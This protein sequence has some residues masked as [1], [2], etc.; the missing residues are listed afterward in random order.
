S[1][2]D[3]LTFML[4]NSSPTGGLL[5]VTPTDV[6]GYATTTSLNVAHLAYTADAG[7][8][9]ASSTLTVASASLSNGTCG[10]FGSESPAID[11]AFT[12]TDGT[13]YRFTLTGTDL[14]GN[15]ATVTQTVKVDTTA[16]SQPAI[17]FTG[18]TPG[19]T[20]ATGSTMWY[21]PT[22]GASFTVNANGSTDGES[23]IATYTFSGNAAQAGNTLLVTPGGGTSTE[24]VHST[25][26]AGLDSLDAS[27]DVKADST[28]PAGGSLTVNGGAAYLTSG[29]TVAIATTPYTDGGSGLANEVLTVQS[30]TLAANN[31]GS[32]GST[33]DISGSASYGV[34][35]GNCYRF[36]LTATDNVGNATV[37]T[38]TV[39]VD[40][41]APVAPAI[42]FTGLSSGN[43][44]VNGTT[45]FYRPSAGGAVTVNATGASDP[46]T[47]IASY[48][49]TPLAGFLS[50]LQTGNKVD[51]IFDG[52]SNGSGAQSVSAVNNAGV[53]STPATPFT[54]T[55]DSG[56]P[57]G[58][59]LSINP[60]SG[61]LTVSIAKTDFADAISGIAT[62]VVTRSNPQ[63]PSSPGTCPLGGYTGST[64]VG[65]SDTVPSDG[66]CYQYT[67][68]GTDNVGNTA[69]FQTIVLVD[70]TGPA[71]GSLAY[72]DGLAT[73]GS[74]SIDWVS[75][76]DPESG[77]AS[78]QIERA[79]ATL[80][81]STCGGFGAFTP[82]GGPVG[83]S[84]TVDASVAAGNCYAYRLVVTNNTG[85]ASTFTS[86]SVAK[87]TNASPITTS[88]GNPAGVYLGG[89]TVWVGP[90]AASLPWKLELTNLGQNGVTTAT[91]D[92]KSAATF[93]SAPTTSTVASS[94]PFQSGTYTW[95]GTGTLTDTIHVIR[96]P[97]GSDD[98]VDVRSDTTN[99]SGSVSYPNATILIHSVP[100]STTGTDAESG[101]SSVSVQRSETTLTGA[102]CGATW[103]AFAPVTLSSGNDTTVAD[104][105]CYRYQ[106]VVTDH[107]GNSSTFGSAS[108]VQIPD[109]TAPTLLSAA[110]NVA[111]TQLT[112]NMSEPL[113]GTATTQASAFTVAYDGVVQ[114]T[115]TGIAVAGS[116]VT[117]NLASA[118]NNSE[119]V[120][121]RYSQP[122]SAGERLRDSASPTKNETANF[123]PSAVVN[124]TPDA[125]APSVVSASVNAS[126]LTILFTETL[127]GAAP[128]P[129]AFTVTIGST[130]RTIT[131][132]SM[133]GKIVTLTFAPAVTS[134]DSVVVSYSTP[135]LN[136]LSDASSNAVAPFTRA[137]AN[138]TPIVAPPTGGGGGV[139]T[140]Q[141]PALASSSPDDG[142]T[143]RAAATI[144]LT[145]N[146]AVSWTD[147]TVTR[148][149]G[150]VTQLDPS[151]GQSATWALANATEGLYVVRGTLAAG[152]S[153]ADVLTHF[154]VWV[155]PTTGFESLV[156]P[157]QKNAVPFAAGELRSSDG[158]TTLV[159]PTGAFSD[160]V[161]VEIVPV[162]LN[163][164][165]GLPP[166]SRIVNVSAFT[167]STHAP[168]HDLGGVADIRF[169]N[170]GAGS[171]PVTST[172][173]K[174][175]RDIP[176]LPTLNLPAGQADG[177]F[178][179]SD[180]TVHVLARH[181]GYYA[182]VGPQVSTRLAMRIITV[183]R[184]WLE[185]RAFV[186]VRMSLTGPARVTGSFV[187]P[188]GTIV[189]GQAIKTPTRHA[190]VTILRVPLTITKPGIYR[191]QMHAEGLGQVVNRTAKI[192]FLATKPASPVWQDGAVR[193]TVVHGAQ[194]LHSLGSALGGHFVVTRVTDAALY[195]AVDTKHPTAA[196]VVVV[197]LRTIPAYTLAGL[198]ALLPE[199]KIIGLSATP[200]RAGAYRSIGVSAVLPGDASAA[201]VAKT[202]RALVR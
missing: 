133:S 51:V 147:M 38:S 156:P 158:S 178:L 92:G 56:A 77:I 76:S 160:S 113:D 151:S 29:T 144:T 143:V 184:L 2:N 123:G 132:V 117:L 189:P 13:C 129:T 72:V 199:V 149:N 34:S 17:V 190:G 66:Q 102:T 165:T 171:H 45:I 166:G 169:A 159:W 108:V 112:L 39:K 135:A 26:R 4:D 23:G 127:A 187:A 197:D 170:A 36:T 37:L 28:A 80:T 31:C 134:N 85:L 99:P 110:T 59:L 86:P 25:N 111:G 162:A 136:G 12:A 137:V 87:I 71:G 20:F 95:D 14:V 104:S 57:T 198:H 30:A 164:V 61:S 191:L 21:R 69:T 185:N 172:D 142:S 98:F 182:L 3:V 167:R 7:S 81:G 152:G 42:S 146:Q 118:P 195:D 150:S 70:T 1:G 43:T 201:L 40:T 22:S 105:T 202:A 141:A 148:P 157:V 183:R 179:D 8:G 24:T 177:W 53:S 9:V 121:V 96:N 58:G 196:A 131:N 6:N 155:P 60:Y 52:T 140:T 19:N 49:F 62:N 79:A 116:T 122:S 90:A 192:R 35:N 138:Q 15:T 153:S 109:V 200:S 64:V 41:T 124:N 97:G 33:S 10:S 139:A 103:S 78:V 163:G 67:L 27:Y 173:G 89:T 115:P 65:A 84:P 54:V 107:V 126:A 120:T 88:A 130:T 161:V 55:P 11:G 68:T 46:E 32:Y 5:N 74:V 128:D 100:V 101:I 73:L 83:S 154:T 181:L 106:V 114:P 175:W 82:L 94:A 18:L 176:G 188:D 47:G 194:G 91:W 63:A 125:V 16:P 93:T 48:A 119:T 44:Y 186:A 145:A 180:G 50:A 75:G 168:V 193:V 174:T